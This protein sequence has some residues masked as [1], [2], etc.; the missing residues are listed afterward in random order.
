MAAVFLAGSLTQVRGEAATRQVGD[1]HASMRGN[2]L[3]SLDCSWILQTNRLCTLKC[4]DLQQIPSCAKRSTQVCPTF[5]SSASN[6]S[7]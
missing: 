5:D 3:N 7:F 2:L 6:I 4:V 1:N